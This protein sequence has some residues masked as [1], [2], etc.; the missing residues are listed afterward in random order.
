MADSKK[1]N[2][3]TCRY[4]CTN[5]LIAEYLY[6]CDIFCAALVAPLGARPAAGVAQPVAGRIKTTFHRSKNAMITLE[7]ASSSRRARK[8]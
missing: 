1:V 6:V 3:H 4:D 8:T 5:C 7:D 2:I